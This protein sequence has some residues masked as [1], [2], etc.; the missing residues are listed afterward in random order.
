MAKIETNIDLFNPNTLRCRFRKHGKE[1]LQYEQFVPA[2]TKSYDR[3]LTRLKKW[4]DEELEHITDFGVGTAESSKLTLRPHFQVYL[5]SKD[6]QRQKSAS[7]TKNLINQILAGLD[8]ADHLLDTPLKKLTAKDFKEWKE[9]LIEDGY[10]PSSINSYLGCFSVIIERLKQEVPNGATWIVNHILVSR[11]RFKRGDLTRRSRIA[12]E[13][14]IQLLLSNTESKTLKDA[15]VLYLMLGC[16]RSELVRLR[17][18]DI[19]LNEPD[20]PHLTFR[21]TKNRDDRKIPLDANTVNVLSKIIGGR[22]KGFVF[23]TTSNSPKVDKDS[24]IT[25]DAITRAYIKARARV[26]K[27]VD[28]P[29]PEIADLRLHDFRATFVVKEA[30]GRFN[31]NIMALSKITGHR[32]IQVL[33]DHYFRA[34]HKDIAEAGGYLNKANPTKEPTEVAQN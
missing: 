16:R 10:S 14:E 31:G 9:A 26:A 19:N 21:D 6:L 23:L 20:V 22:K 25:P 2:S 4:R 34:T 15:L 29:R 32:N 30:L 5:T 28:N 11:L 27:N 12:T 24:A 1:Y 18:E 13:E 7:N 17:I 33:I 8:D 3:A